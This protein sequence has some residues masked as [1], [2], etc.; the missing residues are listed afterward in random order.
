MFRVSADNLEEYLGF[1]PHRTAD[2]E[3][4]HAL[5]RKVAPG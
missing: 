5:I 4:L 2:L 3:K 1:D